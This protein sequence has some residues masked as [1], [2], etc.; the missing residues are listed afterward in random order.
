MSRESTLRR[1]LV[2][3]GVVTAIAGLV[4]VVRPAAIPATVGIQL[5]R[6]A[7]LLSYLLAAAEFGFAALSFS[8]ARLSEGAGLRAIVSSCI[9]LH[10][11]SGLL[12]VVVL[13]RLP[14]AALWINFVVRILVVAV[15]VWLF[16]RAHAAST[17][18]G[19]ETPRD[20]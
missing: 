3:H 4:L 6:D 1:V 19:R 12:E 2:A 10:A 8:G 16:P 5:G 11:A 13:V 17:G 18:S 9:V 7:Y 20:T 14:T 15:F